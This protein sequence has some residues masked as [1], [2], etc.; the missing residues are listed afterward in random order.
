MIR[1][2]Y[3]AINTQLPSPDRGFRLAGYSEARMLDVAREN[4]AA[5]LGVLEWNAAHAIFV[6]RIGSKLVPFA[7]HEVN[8]GVWREVLAEDFARIGAFAREQGMRLS[9]HPG[10]HA[11]LNTPS[12]GVL[13][14]TLR[15]LE[16]HADVL[17]LLGCGCDGRIVLH[18]GGSYGD[19]SGSLERLAER[20]RALPDRVRCRLV[21]END[22]RV[23][24]AEIVR[25]CER[26]GAPG[27]LDVFHHRVLPSFPELP[28]RDLVQRFGATWPA[29]ERQKLHFSTQ[30]PEKARGAHAAQ[31]DAEEF[32]S[33][34]EQVGD[35]EL[36]VML[37]AKDKEGSLLRLRG[38]F[39]PGALR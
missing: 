27:V 37:E 18:C 11:V 28:D 20:F 13:A 22:E 14:A 9:M 29:G 33:F 39:P 17:E 6:F 31:I 26:I 10:Q 19:L 3:V 32:R 23:C 36:D 25:V 34:Y 1:L 8:S 12:E 15:E 24:S 30:H 21:F 38:A 2:G 35:L 5:L 16:Y 7:S 4:L